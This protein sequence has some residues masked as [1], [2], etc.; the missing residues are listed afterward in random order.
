MSVRTAE[1]APLS[2]HR[3]QLESGLGRLTPAERAERGK[4]ARV[5]QTASAVW[6]YCNT[7]L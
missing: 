5:V 6:R 3:Y 2:T 1:A 7:P 4:E